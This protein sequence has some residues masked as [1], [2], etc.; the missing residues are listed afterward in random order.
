MTGSGLQ[1]D[2]L[3]V[4]EIGSHTLDKLAIL[5][6]YLPAFAKACRGAREWYFVDGFSGPGINRLRDTGNLLHGSPLIA[7]HTEPPFTKCIFVDLGGPESAALTQ[8]V[9]GF[10]DRASVHREDVNAELTRLIEEHVPA[11]APCLVLLDP[12]GTEL[13]WATVASIASLKDRRRKPE[14]LILLP[15]HMGFLR[16]LPVD[17]DEAIQPEKLTAMFG[18]DGWRDIWRAKREAKI[19]KQQAIDR[20]VELYAEQ[21]RRLG[22]A[23]VLSRLIRTRGKLGKP[24]YHLVFATEHEAGLRIMEH[25]FD[26]VFEAMQF[27]LFDMPSDE[28]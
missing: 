17:T 19:N 9:A 15:T 26:T 18:T 21:L 20:Y 28:D 23:G 10:G 13:Q 3:L 5:R 1:D 16:M 2:G 12:E 4:R 6:C 27:S 14:V 7:L 24:M 22:Y 11:W 8:R 25:C